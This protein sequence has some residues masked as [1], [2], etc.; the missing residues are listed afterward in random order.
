MC[1]IAK[2]YYNEENHL[3]DSLAF[4]Y[5]KYNYTNTANTC[6]MKNCDSCINHREKHSPYR[7]PEEDLIVVGSKIYPE[8]AFCSHSLIK[9]EIYNK[10]K[11]TGEYGFE[12]TDWYGF[13]KSI[14]YYGRICMD[15]SIISFKILN[16]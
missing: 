15:T 16:R 14:G 13:F 7:I 12:E 4:S 1:D 8:C 5:G 10:V 2:R 6:L 3:Y 11:W 9:T